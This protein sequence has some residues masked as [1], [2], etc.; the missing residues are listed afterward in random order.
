MILGFGSAY[1]KIRNSFVRE[2]VGKLGMGGLSSFCMI[3]S[4]GIKAF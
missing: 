1:F 2:S 3:T 4:V